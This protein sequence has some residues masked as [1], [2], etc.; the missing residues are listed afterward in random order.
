MA[1]YD[2]LIVQM[3]QPSGDSQDLGSRMKI[4]EIAVERETAN[5]LQPIGRGVLV[6]IFL[7]AEM[8]GCVEEK[9]ERVIW[10]GIDTNEPDHVRVRELGTYPDLSEVSLKQSVSRAVC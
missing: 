5:Q 9:S 3:F 10:G 6:E 7:E 1:V 8:T 2:P 4:K